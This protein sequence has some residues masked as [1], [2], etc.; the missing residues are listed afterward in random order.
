MKQIYEVFFDGSYVG[1]AWANSE[2]HAIRKVAHDMV[3]GTGACIVGWTGFM[4]WV[5]AQVYF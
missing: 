4:I 3:I 1:Y 5:A 2:W